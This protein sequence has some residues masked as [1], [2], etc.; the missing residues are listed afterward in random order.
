GPNLSYYYPGKPE[1][2]SLPLTD[3]LVVVDPRTATGRTYSLTP[4][5]VQLTVRGSSKKV[6]LEGKREVYGRGTG[7]IPVGLQYNFWKFSVAGQHILHGGLELADSGV[8]FED[9]AAAMEKE[10]WVSHKTAMPTFTCNSRK[11]NRFE[12]KAIT[13]LG[14]IC[15]VSMRK[16]ILKL[17]KG[18]V[19]RNATNK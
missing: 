13:W 10:V 1:V 4:E 9:T 3:I 6:G 11:P 15:V 7:R 14:H 2:R 8:Q 17:L 12:K 16:F 5:E 18:L 19:Q